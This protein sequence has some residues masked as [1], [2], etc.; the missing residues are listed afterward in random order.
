[1]KPL[2]LLMLRPPSKAHVAESPNAH[3][4][5]LEL[6]SMSEAAYRQLPPMLCALSAS[7]HLNC[8]S[9]LAPWPP[10]TIPRR[11]RVSEQAREMSSY[12]ATNGTSS[13]IEKRTTVGVKFLG[14]G[15]SQTKVS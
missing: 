3:M 10:I 6:D 8:A 4:R 12:V 9:F 1:M 7:R 2:P 15:H 11:Y 5:D 13:V 14:F